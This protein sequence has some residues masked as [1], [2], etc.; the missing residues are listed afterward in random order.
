MLSWDGTCDLETLAINAASAAMA[1]SNVPWNGPVAAVRLA[2]TGS[3]VT[4]HPTLQEMQAASGHLQ[5]TGVADGA[6]VI[7][8]QVHRISVTCSSAP[9]VLAVLVAHAPSSSSA[10]LWHAQCILLLADF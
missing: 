1:C 4:A 6:V 9:F 2:W 3:H 10:S 7:Q 8:A 5:F